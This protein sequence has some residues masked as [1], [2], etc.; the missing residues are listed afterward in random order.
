VLEREI[1]DLLSKVNKTES[2]QAQQLREMAIEVLQERKSLIN[3]Y[4][5]QA[6]FGVATLL[7]RNQPAAGES[8]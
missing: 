4:L 3:N 2:K 8:K 6:R 5:I 7:D 1:P